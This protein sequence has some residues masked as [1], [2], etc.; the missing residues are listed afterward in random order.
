CP[1]ASSNTHPV[2]LPACCGAPCAPRRCAGAHGGSCSKPCDSHHFSRRLLPV[3]RSVVF[4]GTD[5]MRPDARSQCPTKTVTRRCPVVKMMGGSIVNAELP[6]TVT[7]PRRALF[8]EPSTVTQPPCPCS[9]ERRQPS[10]STSGR[11]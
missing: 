7:G 10:V 6:D 4:G 8:E 9:V 3:A 2:R 5:M 1:G 11:G